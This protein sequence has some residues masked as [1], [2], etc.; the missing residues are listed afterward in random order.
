LAGEVPAKV[1]RGD[2]RGQNGPPNLLFGGRSLC[3][4]EVIQ[5]QVLSGDGTKEKVETWA[6]EPGG[7]SVFGEEE[8]RGTDGPPDLVSGGVG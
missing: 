1:E 8:R 7:E 3:N 6:R 4:S 5:L 2:E